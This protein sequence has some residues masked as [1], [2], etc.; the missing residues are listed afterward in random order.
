[1][2]PEESERSF[3]AFAFSRDANLK[4]V[5]VADGIT[6]MLDFYAC[7]HL[8]GAEAESD[9]DMLLFQ[10]GTYDWGNGEFFEVD[11]TRQFIDPSNVDEMSQLHLT[12]RIPPTEDLRALG[13]SDFWCH[14]RDDLNLFKDRIR[15]TAVLE[16]CA[17]IRETRAEL[18]FEHV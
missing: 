10:W 15:D 13:R 3:T 12:F 17:S 2:R 18:R 4:T 5:G 11:I 16:H 9:S 1:M 6:L 8:T 7:V 14:S